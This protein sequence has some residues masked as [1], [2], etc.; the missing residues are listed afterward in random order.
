MTLYRFPDRFE[1]FELPVDMLI[2]DDFLYP[3]VFILEGLS[4]RVDP[5]DRR[6]FY[7]EA[8]ETFSHEIDHVGNA[9][10][11][12]IGPGSVDPFEK[13]DQLPVAFLGILEVSETGGV[14]EIA[15]LQSPIVAGPDIGFHIRSLDLRK[16]KP[17]PCP[18]DNIKRKLA[19]KSIYR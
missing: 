15:E 13:L 4:N 12:R 14:E 2:N 11:H 8:R 1:C 9:H 6:H 5:G 3:H 16:D 7:F 17:G 10:R 19:E 18:A